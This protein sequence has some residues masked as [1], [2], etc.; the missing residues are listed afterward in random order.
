M[1]ESQIDLISGLIMEPFLRWAGGKTWL[2]KEIINYLPKSFND[3][4]EPFLGGGSIFFFTDQVGKSFLSDIN[5]DLIQTYIQVRDNVEEIIN[6]LKEFKN[7]ESDYYKIR[8][9]NFN[10]PT[11]RAA[12]FIY[13]NKTS[14]NGIYRVNR[15]GEYNVPFGYKY[16]T[17]F[18]HQ[19]NL[20]LTSQKLKNVEL[21][22]LDFEE[23]V[24]Q[25]KA[26]DL[27][28]LDPPY[29]V[30]HFNNGFIRYNQ[31]LFSIQDQYRLA[32]SLRTLNHIGAKYIL[33]NAFHEKIEEVFKE[34]GNFVPLTRM[35][36]IGGK[37]AIRQSRKEYMIKNF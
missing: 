28:F 26:N 31:K 16:G 20:L 34:A 19:D 23:A 7:T 13:L 1:N 37:G 21:R 9:L 4:H 11:Q 30:A 12:R 2:K 22:C 32:D 33:T 6:F 3:Y 36:L 17:D 18:I 24:K 5:S 29:T 14:F 15:K 8:S 27:V 25:V 35:S 10:N